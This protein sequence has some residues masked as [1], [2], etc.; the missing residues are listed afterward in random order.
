MSEGWHATRH[1]SADAR[2]LEAPAATAAAMRGLVLGGRG[3]APGVTE[4]KSTGG[5]LKAGD[6]S[7]A[8]TLLAINDLELCF[9]GTLE[10]SFL[11]HDLR[12]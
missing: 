1:R 8:S 11:V 2:S 12:K 6:T 5:E 3:S 4:E 10:G 9:F 7:P